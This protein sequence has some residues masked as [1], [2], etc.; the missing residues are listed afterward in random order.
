MVEGERVLLREME[1]PGP[2][3]ERE[4]EGEDSLRE[5]ESSRK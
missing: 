2:V 3:M 1:I 5:E 4:R